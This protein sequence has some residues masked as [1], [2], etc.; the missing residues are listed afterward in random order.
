MRFIEFDLYQHGRT[1]LLVTPLHA[2]HTN[3]CPQ[4]LR[5]KKMGTRPSLMA[6]CSKCNTRAGPGGA[7]L[8]TRRG[9]GYR[10]RTCR[11]TKQACPAGRIWQKAR[12]WS[13]R[14]FCRFDRAQ[15]III[16]GAQARSNPYTLFGIQHSILWVMQP[17][18]SRDFMSVLNLPP[19]RVFPRMS[20]HSVSLPRNRR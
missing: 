11:N 10:F 14:A 7:R 5:S 13:P 16:A 2:Q 9:L 4:F 3:C 15:G 19:T 8:H 18:R 6:F 12:G 17:M 1:S 20:S